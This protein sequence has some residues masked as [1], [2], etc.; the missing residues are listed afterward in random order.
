MTPRAK[1]TAIACASLSVVALIAAP[2]VEAEAASDSASGY[3]MTAVIDRAR[4]KSVLAGDYE[5][6]IRRS[7]A[8]S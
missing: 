7:M 5:S 6:P 8:D 3:Q 1:V 4:G 2:F